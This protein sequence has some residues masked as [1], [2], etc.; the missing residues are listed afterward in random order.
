LVFIFFLR[1]SSIFLFVFEVVFHIFFGGLLSSWVKI[2][3]HAENQLPR[4]SGSALKVP[5]GWVASYPLSCL[6]PTPVE[7]ELGCDKITAT[8]KKAVRTHI[9]AHVARC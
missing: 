8:L 5:V 4:L 2:R 3:L 7:V 6:A 1:S 9:K